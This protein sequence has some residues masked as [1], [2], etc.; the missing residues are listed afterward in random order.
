MGN[1]REKQSSAM[2][3]SLEQKGQKNRFPGG[4]NREVR[5]EERVGSTHNLMTFAGQEPAKAN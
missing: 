5:W 2:T 3:G 4:G 1:R